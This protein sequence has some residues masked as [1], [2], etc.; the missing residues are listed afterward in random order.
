MAAQIEDNGR[1]W[2]Q[3]TG[4]TVKMRGVDEQTHCK[5]STRGDLRTPLLHEKG[6]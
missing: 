3:A 2:I 1:Y 5:G 6:G 4:D